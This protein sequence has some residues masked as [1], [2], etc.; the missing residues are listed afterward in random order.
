MPNRRYYVNDIPYISRIII[1]YCIIYNNNNVGTSRLSW[2]I[3]SEQGSCNIMYARHMVYS[4]CYCKYPA[5]M[6]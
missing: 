6:W 1:N 4:V 2:K 5:L 3:V